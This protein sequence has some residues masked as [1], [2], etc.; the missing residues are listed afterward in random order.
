MPTFCEKSP[1]VIPRSSQV[2]IVVTGIKCGTG[3]SPACVDIPAVVI[4]QLTPENSGVQWKIEC[5]V[6]GIET[7]NHWCTSNF[8]PDYSY[9]RG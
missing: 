5:F 1:A 8:V 6:G 2:Q 3:T 7:I 9:N 4:P